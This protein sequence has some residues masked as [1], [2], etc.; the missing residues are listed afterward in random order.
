MYR[1][2]ALI[3]SALLLVLVIWGMLAMAKYALVRD[4]IY[5]LQLLYVIIMMAWRV[6]YLTS[7]CD[8]PFV[9]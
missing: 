4:S 1:R 7:L 2:L 6:L 5:T 8:L 3:L 9:Q